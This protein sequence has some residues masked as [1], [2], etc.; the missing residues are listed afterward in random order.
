LSPKPNGASEA[1]NVT[2]DAHVALVA[3]WQLP[4]HWQ[5]ALPITAFISP[6]ANDSELFHA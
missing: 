3:D 5:S 1:A 4:A 2:Y 6:E